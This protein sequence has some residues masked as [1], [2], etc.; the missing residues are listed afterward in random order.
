MDLGQLATVVLPAAFSAGG[1]YVGL[2]VHLH[3]HWREI[4]AVRKVAEA[5]HDRIDHLHEFQ[6]L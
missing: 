3:Y 5:A 2:K 6:K 4:Q 1:A